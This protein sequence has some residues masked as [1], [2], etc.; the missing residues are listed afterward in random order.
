M[1]L[2][3]TLVIA[4][5]MLVSCKPK[6]SFKKGVP[7]FTIIEVSKR[8]VIG[9]KEYPTNIQG[10]NNTE[11]RAK[12]SGYIE[13]LF[14]DEGQ[15][16][17]EGQPI[18]K[19]E[20]N[21]LTQT[22]NAAQSGISA[23]LANVTSAQAAVNAAQVE[24]DKLT[25]L[26]QK[27]II[28]NI[29]LETAKANLQQAI[30][31]LEQAQ[32]NYIQAK[33]TYQGAVANVNYALVKAPVSGVVG[34]IN[35]RVGSLVGPSDISPITTVSDITQL[36][37]YFSMNEKEY[38]NFL[39][40]TSGT[41]IEEKLE[42]APPISL[43]LANGMFYSEKGKLQTVTGQIDPLAGTIQ[44]RVLFPNKNGLLTNGNSGIVRIPTHYNSVIAIPQTALSELQ[45]INYAY[46]LENGDTVKEHIVSVQDK[47]DKIAIINSGLVAGKKI[48]ADGVGNLKT[49][50]VIKPVPLSYDSVINS[51]KPIF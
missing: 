4:I 31:K 46:T 37:A 24:V 19:I 17:Q 50:A 14:V 3:L 36:Y 6:D 49:G 40:T 20:T 35:K 41:T 5:A 39:Q 28:S 8:D 34:K 38:L 16:V 18:F 13:K 7:P 12:I 9:Y 44:F 22:A 32:A 51:L 43:I 2:K 45:G 27:N 15:F 10:S 47:F 25:P 26:V 11:V 30:G 21:I 29:Q 33:A 23:A 42:Q 1:D 48:V